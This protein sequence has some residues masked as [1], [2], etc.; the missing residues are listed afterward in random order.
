ME[1]TSFFDPMLSKIVTFGSTRANAIGYMQDALQQL[2]LAGITTNID[3]LYALVTSND[4]AQGN[5]ST[6]LLSDKNY[7]I[8]LLHDSKQTNHSENE[9]KFSQEAFAALGIVLI[10]F[11]KQQ[12]PNHVAKKTSGK[13]NNHNVFDGWK[14]QQWQ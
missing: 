1:I 5:F 6:Q 7:I 3:F 10:D 8:K 13:T 11:L 9:K 2:F 12:Q 14:I 4:F